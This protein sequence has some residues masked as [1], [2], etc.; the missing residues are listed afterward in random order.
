VTTA[1]RRDGAIIIDGKLDDAAWAK[2]PVF[3]QFSE[4]FPNVGRADTTT[5]VR[6]LYDDDAIYVA[7]QAL[8]A[9]P[10]SIA[11]Q[12]ARRDANSYSDRIYVNIDSYYDRRT[13]FQFSVNPK[14]VQGDAYTSN[15]NQTDANWDAVWDV[16]TRIDA[17]GWTAEFRIPLS[18][19]RYGGAAPGSERTW[20]FQVHR[21]VAR[22]NT[23]MTFSPW[24]P[25][26]SGFTSRFGD[27]RGI[28]D[29]ATPGRL[30][31]LPYVSA[32]VT[33]QPGDPDDPFFRKTDTKPNVGGDVRYGLPGAAMD[34]L[35]G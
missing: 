24:T 16:G 18:Q 11:A 8:D 29:L 12:L 6:V 5:R 35:A 10:D 9:H 30:E 19:L 14:G 20:G 27:L 22:W 15:D 21:D 25:D 3:N 31:V 28:V 23:R 26:G 4:A 34:S 17:E 33:R 13:S 32:K 1:V 7:V 2:A